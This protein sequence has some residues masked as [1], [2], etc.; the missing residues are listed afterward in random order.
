[1]SSVYKSSFWIML[2]LL[3]LLRPRFRQGAGGTWLLKNN[4]YVRGEKATPPL[5]MRITVAVAATADAMGD[6]VRATRGASLSD[7]PQETS[8]ISYVV[9]DDASYSGLQL[10]EF[11]ELLCDAVDDVGHKKAD[12]IL[13]VP[14]VSAAA[15]PVITRAVTP[16]RV[17]L[18]VLRHVTFPGIFT[19][20]PVD[21]ILYHDVLYVEGGGRVKSFMMDLLRLRNTHTTTAFAHKVPDGVSIPHAWLHHGPL[22]L[23]QHV[24]NA[25]Y[26]VASRAKARELIARASHLILAETHG[27]QQVTRAVC[28]W[29][30][31][32]GPA[33]IR[34]F[35]VPLAPSSR[36][37][38]QQARPP[39][40]PLLDPKDCD[41]D[42]A[43]AHPYP[44]SCAHPDGLLPE[45][46]TPPYRQPA[47]LRTVQDIIITMVDDKK[48]QVEEN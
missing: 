18:H 14:F 26:R 15:L 24:D 38:C 37:Q 30:A 27:P 22:L 5:Q 48:Q 32:K 11:I 16:G 7:S 2:L 40:Q 3:R 39:C 43:A 4:K 20:R 42:Y 9:V 33:A 44:I 17:K 35:L 21:A 23:Q 46:R 8:C 25:V 47:F 28:E 31:W 45:C 13:A 29:L 36:N 34:E 1:M 10:A 19:G 6:V 12:V 41:H